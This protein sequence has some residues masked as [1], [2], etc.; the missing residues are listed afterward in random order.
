MFV[1]KV[2]QL[3]FI[4]EAYR[5]L[6]KLSVFKNYNGGYTHNAETHG[7]VISA[8]SN[9]SVVSSIKLPL[10]EISPL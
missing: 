5:L 3:L 2:E 7:Y 10:I 9:S 8:P 1:Y 6:H 4:F